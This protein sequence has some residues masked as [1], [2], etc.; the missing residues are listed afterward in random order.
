MRELN[1]E[2]MD[3]ITGGIHDAKENRRYEIFDG[4]QCPHCGRSFNSGEELQNHIKL[5]HS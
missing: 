1:L 4:V 5:V 3:K 2:E